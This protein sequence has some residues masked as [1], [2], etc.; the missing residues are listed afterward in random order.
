MTR[1]VPPPGPSATASHAPLRLPALYP[2]VNVVGNDAAAGERALA[3]G[4]ELAAAGAT[5]LQLRA[6]SWGAGAL[7]DLTSRM[8]EKLRGSAAF[9]IVNDRA[10]V[11]AACGAHGV[12]VGDEDL[13][14]SAVR[15]VLERG[16]SIE[17]IVGYSTHSV[18]EVA[19][20]S[21]ASGA[22]S[23]IPDYLGFGPVFE[24]PTKAGVREARGLDLLRQ[25]CRAT[26]LPVVAIGG[27]TLATAVACYRAGASSVAA[28]S[29]VERSRDLPALIATYRAAAREAGINYS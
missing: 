22:P 8:L 10:D 26:S 25:A 6:K 19:A 24:S 17:T 13:P 28:I 1:P 12:H 5:L 21:A 15:M 20:V 4:V 23:A 16:A 27:V 3:L 29:E 2:I 11:A 18:A 9:L 7:T 14:V